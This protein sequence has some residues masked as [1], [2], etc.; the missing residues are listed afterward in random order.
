MVILI[1]IEDALTQGNASGFRVIPRVYQRKVFVP[2]LGLLE[3]ST[4]GII[5]Y[6]ANTFEGQLRGDLLLSKLSWGKTGELSK[7][8]L[9]KNGEFLTEGPAPFLKDSSLSIVMGPF[10]EVIMPKYVGKKIVAFVPK[11][12]T[13]EALRVLAV[14]PRRGPRGGVNPVLITGN[15]FGKG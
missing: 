15:G 12:A 13:H 4:N 10:G 7:A 9:S 1:G 8:K 2:P 6:T 14:T 3:S 5:E 11:D